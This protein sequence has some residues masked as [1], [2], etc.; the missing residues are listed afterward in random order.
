MCTFREVLYLIN[1]SPQ[2]QCIDNR[3]QQFAYAP[4]LNYTKKK[5]LGHKIIK[6]RCVMR[7]ALRLRSPGDGYD[8]VGLAQDLQRQY[9]VRCCHT[10]ETSGIHTKKT[11][12]SINITAFY[13][14]HWLR[15]FSYT[16]T[17]TFFSQPTLEDNKLEYLCMYYKSVNEKD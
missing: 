5:M 15:A 2:E 16:E 14:H 6:V 11:S 8:Q 9:N 4:C 3:C 10:D 12:C 13:M 7:G 1:P 17:F